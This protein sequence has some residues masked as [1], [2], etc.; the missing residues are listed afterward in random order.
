MLDIPDPASNRMPV[1]GRSAR[2]LSRNLFV[3]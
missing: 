3:R 2:N 1:R